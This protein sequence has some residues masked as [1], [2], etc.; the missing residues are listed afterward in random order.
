MSIFAK[1]SANGPQRT[2]KIMQLRNGLTGS[3]C[4]NYFKQETDN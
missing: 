2:G 1:E 4:T 3:D